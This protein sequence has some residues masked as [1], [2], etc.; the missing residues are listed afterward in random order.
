[1][2]KVLIAELF[3]VSSLSL[4]AVPTAVIIESPK[5]TASLDNTPTYKWRAVTTSS[6][7]YLWVNDSTGNKIKKW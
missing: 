3:F 7:Y 6:W 2:L 1:M 5:N 4:A